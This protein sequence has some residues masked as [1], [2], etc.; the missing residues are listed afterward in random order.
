MTAKTSWNWALWTGFV[1]VLTG[2]FS[3][4]FFVRFP[5]T[6]D[7]PWANLLLFGIGAVLLGMGWRRAFR[8]E[9]AHRGKIVGPILTVISLF[10]FGLFA[11]AIFYELRQLPVS[12]GVP[13]VGAKAPNFVLPDQHG[14]RTALA[15]LLSSSGTRAAVVIFYRGY[16]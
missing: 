9:N 10:V 4:F 11:Y 12:S 13:R 14:K 7:F 16:W 15:D 1:F 5:V 8:K 2:F 6:R 3:Y